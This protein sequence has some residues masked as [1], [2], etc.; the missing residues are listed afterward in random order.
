MKCLFLKSLPFLM[1]KIRYLFYIYI[2]RFMFYINGVKYGS[3]LRVFNRFYLYKNKSAYCVIGNNFTFT[4][5]EAFNPLSRNVRGAIYLPMESS[6][7]TIGDNVGISS[8]CIW[9]QE[10]ITIGNNV[11][12]GADCVILDTDCHNLDYKVRVSKE[13]M[14]NGMSVDCYTANCMP[15]VIED[16]VLIGTRCII[17]KGV[18]IG[19]RSIIAAGSVVTKSIPCDCI[20]GGNPC[21]II[22][23]TN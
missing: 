2:N 15:I 9:A 23:K 16:N 21:R 22:R 3:N 6:T 13:R 20:A 12:I 4:S 5:G 17:L 1:R 8:A 11:N 14:P 18:T 19:E 10:N 7:L